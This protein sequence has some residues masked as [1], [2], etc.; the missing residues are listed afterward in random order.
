MY[1]LEDEGSAIASLR[2]WR[3]DAGS[4]RK[5]PCVQWS[6]AHDDDNPDLTQRPTLSDSTMERARDVLAGR[7]R[8]WAHQLAFVGPSVTASI[9]YMPT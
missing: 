1:L 2:R 8:G 7:R 6:A 4:A 9:A 5:V 3:D